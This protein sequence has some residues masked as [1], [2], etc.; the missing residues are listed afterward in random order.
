MQN[1]RSKTIAGPESE[2]LKGQYSKEDSE[3]VESIRLG[4]MYLKPSTE[5]EINRRYEEN[6]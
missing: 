3:A 5:T 2:A 6:P 4:S 1:Q